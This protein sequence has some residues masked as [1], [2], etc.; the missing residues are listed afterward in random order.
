[1]PRCPAALVL[2][3]VVTLGP[4]RAQEAEVAIRDVTVISGTGAP[5]LAAA[6]V[7]IQGRRIIAVGPATAV[8]IP[9]GAL[10]IDGRGKF[11][12][13]GL[14]D[15]HVHI[16][17]SVGKPAMDVE[18]ALELAHGVTGMR[19]ASAVGHERGL[20]ELRTQIDSGKVLGPRLYVS[21]SGTPQNVPRHQASG[22]EDLVRHLAAIG[23]DGI[24]LRNLTAAQADTVI[25]AARAAGL[26]SFGHTYSQA[27][28]AWDFTLRAIDRGATG[29]MHVAG[30]GPATRS[31]PREVTATG[32]QRSWLAT[33]LQ[34]TDATE[35]EEERLLKALLDHGVWLEPTFTADAFTLYDEWYRGRAET[36]FIW[37]TTYDSARAGHPVFQGRDLALARRGFTRMQR[38]VRRFQESGGTVLAGSDMFPWP[39]AGIHEELR[40]LVLAGLSPMAALQAATRNAART[41]GWEKKTGT[42]VAGL[43]ADL[44]LLDADPLQE[45]TNTTKIWKVVRAGRVLDRETLDSLITRSA[46]RRSP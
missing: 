4:L 29:V 46:V 21:G 26:P 22:L 38:F 23:V 18:L 40:L 15:T 39:G 5:A 10:V 7:L 36:R 12:I 37:W 41:L 32:W 45:I 20:V 16:A 8:E 31:E 6:T 1:M 27:D 2:A 11:L 35:G 14:I 19:D 44:V 13:P 9:A 28:S 30:I 3:T 42:I 24:K 25:A 17:S 43:E 34:W 33:Y